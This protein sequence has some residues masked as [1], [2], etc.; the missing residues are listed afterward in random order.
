[1]Q[2]VY[3]EN[4]SSKLCHIMMENLT[5]TNKPNHEDYTK[6]RRDAQNKQS[7]GDHTKIRTNTQDNSSSNIKE[8]NRA[9]K[10]T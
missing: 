7:Y 4:T 8:T 3:R 5:K 10:I 6:T 9:I 2:D 1:M